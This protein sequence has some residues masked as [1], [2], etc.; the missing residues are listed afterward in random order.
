MKPRPRL[1]RATALAPAAVAHTIALSLSAQDTVTVAADDII[2]G[3]CVIT[4]DTVV[5]IGGLDGPGLE[6]LRSTSEVAVDRLGRILI[7]EGRVSH[8][9]VFDSTG[10]FL[11]TVGR[12]GQGPGEYSFISHINAGPRY[13]H[14]FDMRRRTLLDHD[15]NP[16]KI[17]IVPVQVSYSWVTESDVIAFTADLRTR[18]AVGHPLHLLRPTGEI[19][20]HGGDGSVY[21]RRDQEELMATSVAG[22]DEALWLVQYESNRL[23]RWDLA[24]KPTISRVFERAIEEFDRHDPETWPG[25]ANLG[26]MLDEDGLWIV[27]RAPE[28]G[29]DPDGSERPPTRPMRTI[30]DSW[31]DLVDPSTGRTIARHWSDGFLK[32]FAPGSRYVFA[33]EESEA[34]VP[35]IHLMEPALSRGGQAF[36][37][38]DKSARDQGEAGRNR[39]PGTAPMADQRRR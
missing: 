7:S 20:S 4:L 9:S 17:D 28:S 24:E 13:I 15:F 6:V 16:V 18:E 37:D 19:S 35:Y 33:Y 29:W 23:I 27:W 8:F 26:S 34:G 30:V 14:V 3:D 2:C 11:R 10:T 12:S 36:R 25:A 5:T 21:R 38:G 22:D 31:V 39:R 1:G 32:G